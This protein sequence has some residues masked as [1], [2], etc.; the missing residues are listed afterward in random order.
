MTDIERIR[1][2]YAALLYSTGVPSK[3]DAEQL[4]S[5]LSEGE[6]AGHYCWRDIDY[7]E[8]KPASWAATNHYSRLKTIIC[9]YGEK[10]LRD[11]DY[12]NKI[13]GAIRFW[14]DNNFQ[15]PNWWHNDIGTPK[16]FGE[17][18]I[19]LYDALDESGLANITKIT[20]QGS[21]NSRMM[22]GITKWTGANLLWGAANTVNHALLTNDTE[23]LDMG[24]RLAHGEL[25]V[26]AHEGIQ[27]DGSFFQH[28]RLLYSGGY[29]R[30]FAADVATL[31]YILDGTE[32]RFPT[33][34]L[35]IFEKHILDGLRNMTVGA[36]LDWQCLGREYVR[37]GA[38]GVRRIKDALKLMTKT[39]DMPR[40]DEISGYL[41]EICGGEKGDFTKYF[42]TAHMLCHKSNGIYVGTR[43][44]DDSLYASEICNNENVLGANLA[45]GTTTCI[46]KTGDEYYDIAPVWNY[47]RIP[48]TTSRTETDIELSKRREWHGGSFS[49]GLCD[50]KQSGNRAIVCQGVKHDGIEGLCANFAFEGGFVCLGADIKVTDGREEALVTTVDQRKVGTEMSE[51]DN[52][53]YIDGVCYITLDGKELHN[54]LKRVHGKWTRNNLHWPDDSDVSEEILTLE[55]H[56]EKGSISS[57]AYLI[58]E[59]DNEPKVTVLCNDADVQAILLTDGTVMAVFHNEATLEYGGKKLTKEKG[60]YIDSL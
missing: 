45:Y 39:A 53:F 26:G 60:I 9:G 35:E 44:I 7:T 2:R 19:M 46:M 5:T 49:K 43:F 40:A 17:I 36:Y 52:A 28:G 24:A 55:I 58:C 21:A 12:I 14:A 48:G 18:G 38:V 29:G 8:N 56:H 54:T 22:G 27:H 16:T 34:K 42:E 25:I 20:A 57:Y 13:S 59:E 32:Y 1:K 4:F 15:N 23:C 11:K 6:T 41:N 47:S 37:P 51:A 30:S 3:H 31:V 10:K 50:G 33:E